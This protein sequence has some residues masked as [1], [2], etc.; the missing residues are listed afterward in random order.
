MKYTLEELK[1]EVFKNV[2]NVYEI[3]QDFFGE[4][5]VDLQFDYDAKYLIPTYIDEESLADTDLTEEELNEAKRLGA[6]W[7]P[8]I[9]V[10][11]PKV[12]VT[13]EN[14][15]SIQIKDLY[16]K[17]QVNINGYIPFEYN[18]FQ[19][20]R[21]SFPYVQFNEGYIHSHVPRMYLNN[22]HI[23]NLSTVKKW[24]FPC[25]GSGP[26]RKTILDLHTSNEEALWLLF[27]QEL[28]MYVTVES[29]AGGPY[30]RLESVGRG[31]TLSIYDDYSANHH[32]R[33]CEN[34][35][36]LK[37]LSD[38]TKYYVDHGNLS[39]SFKEGSFIAGMPFYDFIMD[40]S[41]SFISWYNSL[42]EKPINKDALLSRFTEEAV[43]S[44]RK[45]YASN[46]YYSSNVDY[47]LLEGTE[48]F[49]FK[50]HAIKLHVEAPNNQNNEVHKVILLYKGVAMQILNNILSLINYKYENK[51]T[52]QF[53][54]TQKSSSP[55][56]TKVC[57]I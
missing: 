50:G 29:L 43:V 21:S 7:N 5:F 57:Y 32:I 22:N 1:K 49:T 17:V 53:R 44:E 28:S 9:Y 16:A 48:L 40:I 27:C 6:N 31:T 10:W 13:N 35:E 36:N 20:I 11:W 19:L 23:N 39:F 41:N 46:R 14:N 24:N 47:S 33:H 3:F 38:F 8:S 37:I 55:I 12:T 30:Y 2:Y 4:E 54:R 26:I 51:Y 25:L 34:A 56:S 42:E 45:F 52:K 15:Q 18:G